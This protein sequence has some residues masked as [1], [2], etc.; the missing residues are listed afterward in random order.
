MIPFYHRSPITANI[1]CIERVLLSTER[2][3]C[4][5]INTF[6][7]SS[8]NSLSNVV[9]FSYFFKTP[10]DEFDTG[11]VFEEIFEDETVLPLW[12]GKIIGKVEIKT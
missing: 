10:S 1:P 6:G 12:D 11:A 2:T 7:N 8:T 4:R 5:P 9:V 3:Y